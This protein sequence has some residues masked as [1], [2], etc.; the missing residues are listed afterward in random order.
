MSK[1]NSISAFLW[2]TVDPKVVAAHY[3]RIFKSEFEFL[4]KQ[5]GKGDAPAT[6]VEFRLAGYRLIAFHGTGEKKFNTAISFMV[7]CKDQKTIDKYWERFL[8]EGGSEGQCGW[9]TDKYGVS[10]QIVPKNLPKL[11]THK[12][13]EGTQAIMNEF[14][15]MKKI[16]T[17]RLSY[18]TK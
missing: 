8:S 9:L 18:K 6:A 3:K 10:W 11:L 16:E 17:S 7:E 4:S 12:T 13:E 1:S 2:F 15:K 5:G 14:L